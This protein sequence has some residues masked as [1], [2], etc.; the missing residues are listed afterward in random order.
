MGFVRRGE[1]R[2]SASC[3]KWAVLFTIVVM[4]FMSTLDGSIVNVAVPS[5]QRELGVSANDIQWVASVYMLVCCVTVL[6]FGRLGDLFGKVRF[7][8]LGVALF[9]VGSLL[10]GLSSTL[11][12]LVM[13][14]V[15]QG[16]GA[17]SALANNMGIATEAFPECER[18]RAL[19]IISTFISLGLM[20]GPVLGGMLVASYPWEAI[21]LVNVPVGIVAF[22]VGLKTLPADKRPQSAGAEALQED[23]S[24]DLVGAVLLVPAVFGIF[25]AMTSA[26]TKV[27]ALSLTLLAVGILCL[28]AFVVHERNLKSCPLVRLSLFKSGMFT[29]NLVTMLLCFLAVGATEFILPFFLQDACGY[30]SDVAGVILTAI[31]LAMAVLGP[32]SGALADRV[33]ST[34][35]CLAGL[36]VYAVGIAF[37]GM[38]P[39]DAGVVRIYLALLFMSLGMGL[40][41]S[42]NNSLVMGSVGPED[43]GF[44]GSLVSLV[45]YVGMSGGV[46]GGTVLLYGRMGA[47]AGHTVTGFVPGEPELFMAGFQFTFWVFAALVAAAAIL[48]AAGMVLMRRRSKGL[49]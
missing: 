37:A 27:D 41:Q 24:F 7:F 23:R 33:G 31:P 43:L 36:A 17:S 22:F 19:G 35:P 46:T 29:L 38:L 10:C 49:R 21:F 9:T 20:C 40:F 12:M 6:V 2:A 4:S 32:I 14:R 1:A 5:M 39:T 25:W 28:G 45:R 8:H 3:N 13:S 47:L 15:V 48:T 18:G 44:A 42:P 30:P 26:A 11:P 34:G 16:I